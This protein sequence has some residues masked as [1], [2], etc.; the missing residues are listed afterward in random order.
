MVDPF[1]SDLVFHGKD[2]KNRKI[3]MFI[4]IPLIIFSLF[5]VSAFLISIV[6]IR[7]IRFH[8]ECACKKLLEEN[9]PSTKNQNIILPPPI[10][11][12]EVIGEP[13]NH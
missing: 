10:L 8:P 2:L 6:A 12:P 5:A 9:P 13:L 1:R 3:L 7:R 11:S 4:F